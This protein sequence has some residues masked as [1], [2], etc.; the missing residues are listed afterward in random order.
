MVFV[1]TYSRFVLL[2]I[3]HPTLKRYYIAQRASHTTNRALCRLGNRIPSVRN[4]S[5]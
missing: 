5:W 4:R 2:N 3:I 1:G